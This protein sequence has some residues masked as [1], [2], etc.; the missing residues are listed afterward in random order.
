M[1]HQF[2]YAIV[3]TYTLELLMIIAYTSDAENRSNLLT[4]KICSLF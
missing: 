3:M 2:S 1:F 4:L